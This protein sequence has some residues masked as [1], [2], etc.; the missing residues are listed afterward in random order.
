[1]KKP[2]FS[3]LQ[4]ALLALLGL[5]S[6]YFHL[7]PLQLS[8]GAAVLPDLLLIIVVLWTVRAPQNAPLLLIALLFLLGDLML[9]RPVGL[10]ALISLLIVEVIGDRRTALRNRPFVAEWLTFS[11][12]LAIGLMLHALLLKL[13]LV[14]RPEGLLALRYFI[15]T[16]AAYPVMA[17]LLH[18]V[19]RVRSPK[20]VER[21]SRLGRVA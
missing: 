14:Q 19:F 6:I 3:L 5:L 8:A 2:A 11:L 12:A 1:M 18:Y 7:A 21:S 20:P 9:Q 4:T 15:V 10:W 16:V 13:A 17:A